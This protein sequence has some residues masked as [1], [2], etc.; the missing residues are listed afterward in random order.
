MTASAGGAGEAL[1]VVVVGAGTMGGGIAQA[2]A[3]A[4][5][6]VRLFDAA[7]AAARSALE[8]IEASLS[9]LAAKDRLDT[10]AVPEV[11]ARIEAGEEHADEA[12]GDAQVVIE[13]I[14]EDPDVKS[15]VW[16]R[17]GAAAADDA[18]L[19]SNTSSLS[20]TALG[21][22]SGRPGDL[23]GLH[24]FN[25]V[26]VLPLVEVVRGEGTRSDT[27]ERAASFAEGL[28][29]TPVRCAD[30]PGF[31]VNRLLIPYLNEAATLLDEG[32]ADAD[33]IDTAMRLGT[34]VPMGPLALADLIGLDVVLAVMESLHDEF[35]DPRYRPAPVL[36][37]LV[38]AGRLGRKSGH[39]FRLHEGK[40]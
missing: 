30:R 40:T 31:L 15:S 28:G 5:H 34:G 38:R 32:A 21:A 20:I 2:C 19:A 17:L 11:L 14:T 22:A 4:G 26:A 3:Q 39:G 36:R 27:V 35:G 7:P 16:S 25:P 23:C 24:F 12:V 10:R 33:A 37:R 8:R 18:L 1:R 6:R 29:K 13:A 9:R